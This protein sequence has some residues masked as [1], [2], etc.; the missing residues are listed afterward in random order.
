[1]EQVSNEDLP[2]YTVLIPVFHEA[3]MLA[4]N[5]RNMYT[6][7]YPKNKL[8]IKILME[9]NDEETLSEAKQLGLFGAPTKN[10]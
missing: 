7:D 9:E 4:Q 10:G 1:M 6:L 8:D 5:L 3:K 2:V